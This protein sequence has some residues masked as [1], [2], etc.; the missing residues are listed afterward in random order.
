MA[1]R[2]GHRAKYWTNN[3]C[4]EA[5]SVEQ[6]SKSTTA[7]SSHNEESERSFTLFANLPPELRLEIWRIV[8]NQP[9]I[10]EV[11]DY[12]RINQ[13]VHGRIIK[14]GQQARKPPAIMSVNVESRYEGIR[15]YSWVTFDSWEPSA[16][17]ESKRYI[18]YNPHADVIYFGAHTCLRTLNRFFRRNR[19]DR[20][21][22][23]RIAVE[24]GRELDGC[25]NYDCKYRP[26]EDD[27]PFQEWHAGW[28]KAVNIILAVHG[29]HS[30][31]PA[32]S[33]VM[34]YYPG[35][36]GLRELFI[37]DV[38]HSQD[39]LEDGDVAF[40][41]PINDDD[42]AWRPE[43]HAKRSKILSMVSGEI[44][45]DRV[46][47]LKW[48][49]WRTKPSVQFVTLSSQKYEGRPPLE[50]EFVPAREI[51]RFASYRPSIS[52]GH[53]RSIEPATLL[54]RRIFT[55]LKVRLRRAIDKF[56]TRISK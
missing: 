36:P 28:F 42:D 56:V 44:E 11:E 10:L 12:G 3:H 29:W 35:C 33:R 52:A 22:I 1:D 25:S 15:F 13:G 39:E 18:F 32:L 51:G 7:P 27:H 2:I 31:D 47:A 41:H 46:R 5:A 53:G 23:L 8:A 43:E 45:T 24:T 6:T 4:N 50:H 19:G 16:F 20:P 40:F 26:P 9:R 14:M 34:D 37:V 55:R 49:N 30:D 48:Q 21:E 54:K 17:H 38:T